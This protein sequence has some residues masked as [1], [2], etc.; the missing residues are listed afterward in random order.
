MGIVNTKNAP[1]ETMIECDRAIE[2]LV[3]EIMNNRSI[4]LSMVPDI[5]E[6]RIYRRL[7]ILLIG[8]IK[9]TL[10]EVSMDVLHHRITLTITPLDDAVDPSPDAS[11]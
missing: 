7:L 1:P 5:I 10:S 11:S 8:H 6:R 4:N 2:R 9:E 3:D